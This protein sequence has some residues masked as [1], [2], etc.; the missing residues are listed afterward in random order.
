MDG[1]DPPPGTRVLVLLVISEMPR[2]R[3]LLAAG[4]GA[5]L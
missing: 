2:M 4:A 5:W 1:G 3:G